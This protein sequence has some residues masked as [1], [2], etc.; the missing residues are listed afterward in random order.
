MVYIM[1]MSIIEFVLEHKSGSETKITRKL[2]RSAPRHG[3]TV[4]VQRPDE[5]ARQYQVRAHHQRGTD[6]AEPLDK[7]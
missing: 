6:G 4:D 3:T 2:G 1:I 7:C 5:Q